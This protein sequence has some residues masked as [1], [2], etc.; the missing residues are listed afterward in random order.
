MDDYDRFLR[1]DLDEEG[2][3]TSQALFSDEKGK[4]I[5]IA[6]EPCVVAGLTEAS[7]VF[8]KTGA[9]CIHLVKDGEHVEKRTEI[10]TIS[11][12]IC[13]IL[14]AERLA[15]NFLGRM[16]A[17]A[18]TTKRLVDECS[19]IN[20]NVSIAATRK[21]TP[22]FRRYEKKAVTIAGGE[23]HRF[24]L[25]DAVMIKDNHIKAIGSIEKAITKVK[26]QITTKTIEIE[27]E[28][29]T[30]AMIAA[31]F[32]V[33][34]IMLD[35]FS[36]ERGKKTAQRIRKKNPHILIELSG[37]ITPENIAEYA[38]FAD[39]ISMGYL[40]HTVINKDFSLTLC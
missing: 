13:S 24:G 7:I 11:G 32:N 4:A 8:E 31:D 34:V 28:N 27:V 6:K 2:D 10:A 19:K 39:R 15:L 16:S 1:E 18:T 23:P 21:T 38:S 40:T 22:G 14:K 20:P 5:I 36:A 30:D 33:D 25:F 17:I 12:S 37:G 3:I 35:N 29:E 9:N 26:N